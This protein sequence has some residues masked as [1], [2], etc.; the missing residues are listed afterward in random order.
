MNRF[1]H[2]NW[3]TRESRARQRF[4]L[5]FPNRRYDYGD[6]ASTPSSVFREYDCGGECKCE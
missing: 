2:L 3:P 5:D 1:P 6:P 4:R